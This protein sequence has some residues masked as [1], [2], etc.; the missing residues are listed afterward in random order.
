MHTDSQSLL[1]QEEATVFGMCM[2]LTGGNPDLER[3]ENRVIAS[4]VGK[5]REA[6]N[7]SSIDIQGIIGIYTFYSLLGREAS[8]AHQLLSG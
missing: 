6:C 2:G 5:Q 1:L 8:I 3:K 7:L 4:W